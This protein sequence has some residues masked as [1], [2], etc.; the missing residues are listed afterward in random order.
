MEKR[1]R[2]PPKEV[3]YAGEIGLFLLDISCEAFALGRTWRM[4]FSRE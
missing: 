1:S 4:R 3:L 2:N